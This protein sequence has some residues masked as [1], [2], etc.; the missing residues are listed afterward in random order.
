M[1]SHGPV[2]HTIFFLY[3]SNE[4]FAAAWSILFIVQTEWRLPQLKC[5][6]SCISLILLS[7]WCTEVFLRTL[8]WLSV[9]YRTFCQYFLPVSTCLLI[10]KVDCTDGRLDL[11]LNFSTGKT[12]M[13]GCC[14][15]LSFFHFF[16]AAHY[17]FGNLLLFA[18]DTACKY[19]VFQNFFNADTSN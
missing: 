19:S 3:L 1:Q 8:L 6:W 17:F 16:L 11:L 10:L 14:G 12:Y 9:W 18:D 7:C 13:F 4:F 15:A 5:A 2:K